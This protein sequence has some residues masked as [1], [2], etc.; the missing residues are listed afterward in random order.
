MVIWV[1]AGSEWDISRLRRSTG[2]EVWW[3]Q[4]V[5]SRKIKFRIGSSVDGVAGLRLCGFLLM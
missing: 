2:G 1:R 3:E 5:G 4:F